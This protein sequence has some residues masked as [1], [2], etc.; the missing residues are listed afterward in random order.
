MVYLLLIFVAG[1]VLVDGLVGD[2]GLVAMLR[3]R[4]EYDDP[5]AA[6]GCLIHPQLTVRSGAR[7]A[8]TDCWCSAAARLDW[9]SLDQKAP[10]RPSPFAAW[11]PAGARLT[12]EVEQPLR[13]PSSAHRLSVG[14]PQ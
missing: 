10:A 3:A 4:H 13:R 1:A 7:T 9:P 8:A 2:R 12:S 6:R 5:S 14:Q 11:S